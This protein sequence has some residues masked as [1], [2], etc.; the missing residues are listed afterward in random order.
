MNENIFWE[1]IEKCWKPFNME[2]TRRLAISKPTPQVLQSLSK[3][4]NN[5]IILLLEEELD[6]LSKEDLIHYDEILERK[7]YDI[8]REELYDVIEGGDDL[9]LYRRG[10]I[11]GIGKAYYDSINN[12]PLVATDNGVFRWDEADTACE[13]MSLIS[14]I[15]YQDKFDKK[16]REPM[17]PTGISRESG[18]NKDKWS[19]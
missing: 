10:F 17:P 12:N 13:D 6:K 8:D 18:S 1:L 9:F 14:C 16:G 3:V 7:L 4:L 19:Y 11:V 15:I 2:E 5:Q